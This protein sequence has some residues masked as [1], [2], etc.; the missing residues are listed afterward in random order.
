MEI[1][2]YLSLFIAVFGFYAGII[3]SYISPEEMKDGR[4]Y[5]RIMRYFI[6]IILLLISLFFMY[7]NFSF[8]IIIIFGLLLLSLYFLY[9]NWERFVFLI[10]GIVLGLSFIIESYYLFLLSFIFIYGLPAGSLL[11]KVKELSK[12]YIC[13]LFFIFGAFIGILITIFLF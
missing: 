12:Y 3:L 9:I 10:F 1:L 4:K 2:S 8:L 13:P 7:N 6:I 5:F 11:Y